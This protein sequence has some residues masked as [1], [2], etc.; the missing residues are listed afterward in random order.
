MSAAAAAAKFQDLKEVISSREC[1]CLNE[2]PSFPFGNLFIGDE[3]L[4]LKSDA[5][6]NP[7]VDSHARCVTF[8]SL[9]TG[10]APLSASRAA[11]P[12]H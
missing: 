7:H 6:G 4:Q 5:D 9:L 1:Y 11:G 10:Y 12:A 8:R 2:N 3:T